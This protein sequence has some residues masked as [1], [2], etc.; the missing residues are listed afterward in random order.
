[1]CLLFCCYT[2]SFLH[3]RLSVGKPQNPSPSPVAVETPLGG[4]SEVS[5]EGNAETNGTWDDCGSD[6]TGSA[7][8]SSSVW[9]E[10]SGPGDRTSR[11]ALILQMAKARMK[12]N[13]ESPVSASRSQL[14]TSIT[15]EADITIMTDANTIADIDFTGDLD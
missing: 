12:T 7:V 11:R 15:E 1:V 8:S 10:N 2:V 9:T 4:E 14:N 3:N 6:F 13:K 5:A